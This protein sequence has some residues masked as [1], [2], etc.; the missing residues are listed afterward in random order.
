MAAIDILLGTYN[1]AAYLDEQLT[2]LQR[3]SITDWRVLARDDGSTDD[4]RAVLARWAAREP[5][6][7][8]V[9][10]GRGNLGFSANFH[11]LLG[12]AQAPYVMFCDQDDRW[13]DTKIER[14]WNA[15]QAQEARTPGLPVLAHCDSTVTN[16][17]FQPIQARLVAAWARGRGLTSALFTNP[18]QGSTLM[19][20]AALRQLLL[21]H[22][23][24]THFDYQ[25]ALI[26]EATGYRVFVDDALLLYR[27]HGRN[28]LGAPSA[29]S[30]TS[31]T[32]PTT[33]TWRRP[34]DT[35][36]IGLEGFDRVDHTLRVVQDRWHPGTAALLDRHRA[37]IRPGASWEKLR[38][39][40]RANYTFYRR[41]DRLGAWLWALGWLK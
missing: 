33:P 2:S 38:W 21:R 24:Q 20:N 13:L 35:L 15:L 10:D 3:Q 22:P 9:R 17:T 26:A 8:V 30:A 25:A 36:R 6:I 41:K 5:R 29:P 12:L 39:L 28:A 4:T 31:A 19:M 37:F 14:T 34:S 27:Q 32:I 1:G 16:E 40:W 18:V 23:P 11:H 7:T